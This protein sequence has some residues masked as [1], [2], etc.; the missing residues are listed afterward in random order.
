M[1]DDSQ[2]QSNIEISYKALKIILVTNS[3][4]RMP[5]TNYQTGKKFAVLK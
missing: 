1:N 4:N 2:R 5:Q 3:I